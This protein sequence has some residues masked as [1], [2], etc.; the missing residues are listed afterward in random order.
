MTVEETI[1]KQ[2]NYCGVSE[3]HSK[4]FKGQG[5]T[6]WNCEK[7]TGDHGRQ[8]A[9]RVLDAAPECNLVTGTVSM[10]VKGNEVTKCG[11]IDNDGVFHDIH[12]WIQENNVRII[13]ASMKNL[14][15]DKGN[16]TGDFWQ[17]I[18]D[19]YGIIIVNSAGN[20]GNENFDFTKR[21]AWHVGALT[22]G[23]DG[24]P[25]R[26][27]YS[28]TG[29]GLDFADFAGWN[30]GTS[31]SAPYFAGKCALV[32]QKHPEFTPMQ[33]YDY[34]KFCS[35][36]LEALGEDNKTGWGLPILPKLLDEQE[37]DMKEKKTDFV[38]VEAGRWSEEAIAY[39]VKEGIMRGMGDGKFAPTQP[40]TR[41]QAAQMFY[42]VFKE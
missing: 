31:F 24:K 17:S 23:T 1:K 26:A 37:K 10:H 25:K 18:I 6:V 4:G 19:K 13:T 15:K 3:W 27:G 20:D 14:F 35:M 5:I 28:S 36:D 29:E 38:D 39:C 34:M 12:D 42:N 41:E 40:L 33:V 11:A 9:N 7:R 8:S 32:L 22:L 21:V 2:N 30:A 16:A